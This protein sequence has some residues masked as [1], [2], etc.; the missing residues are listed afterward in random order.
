MAPYIALLLC[1]IF[2]LV[3]FIIDSQREPNVSSALWIPLIWLV[4]VASRPIGEWSNPGG[5][6]LHPEA[7]SVI[8]QSVLTVLICLAA[9]ILQKRNFRWTQWLK[10]NSWLFLFFLY[11]GISVVWSDFP[12]VACKRWIRAVGSLMMVFV[13]LSENDPIE[14]LVALVRRCAY[15]LVPL[16]LLFIKYYR[17]IAV[18]FNPWTGEEYLSGVTTDKNALGRLCLI[19]GLFIFWDLVKTRHHKNLIPKKINKYIN[20]IIFKIII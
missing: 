16:S 4:I 2:I 8:D 14:A 9:F 12:W 10:G 5:F 20:I 17:N 15:L 1:S 7:G 6:N 19:T 3:A 13:V 18:G 11:C